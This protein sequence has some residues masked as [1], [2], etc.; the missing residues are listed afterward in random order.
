M[1]TSVA[2][3][4]ISSLKNLDTFVVL[5]CCL[6]TLMRH[7][8]LDAADC[9]HICISHLDPFLN[10]RPTSPLGHHLSGYLY[11]DVYWYSHSPSLKCN[12]PSFL[13]PWTYIS[14][15]ADVFSVD[16]T[17][18]PVSQFRWEPSLIPLLLYLLCA[19]LSMTCWFCHPVTSPYISFSLAISTLAQADLIYWC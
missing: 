5:F 1:T 16:S 15:C 12:L 6:H 7:H 8:E 18:L 10:L 19:Y 13:E 4:A 2:S 17:I 3:V 14:L 11:L 9:F